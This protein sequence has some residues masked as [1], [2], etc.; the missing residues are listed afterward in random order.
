[1]TSCSAV[2]RLGAWAAIAAAL[3]AS[4]ATANADEARHTDQVGNADQVDAETE[5][6]RLLAKATQAEEQGD[7]TQAE[8]LLRESME[9]WPWSYTAFR[10]ATL[11]G[12]TGRE[13]EAI[14]LLQRIEQREFGEVEG[15]ALAEMRS[16][17]T[18]LQARLATLN[19]SW[20]SRAAVAIRLDEQLVL[21]VEDREGATLQVDPGLRRLTLEAPGA[22]AIER[23][24]QLNP[25]ATVALH[26]NFEATAPT[27]PPSEQSAS[28]RGRRLRRWLGS[29]AAVVALAVGAVLLL[30]L[31]PGN[32]EPQPILIPT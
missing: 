28:A 24:L 29:M 3:A 12:A 10:L 22:R 13:S 23:E 4:P 25:G 5:G 18:R 16:E 20:N 31:L 1:M 26:L 15:R 30:V 32:E 17:L 11:L 2:E 8:S 21:E 27:P 6:Q 14:S 7:L 19:L 9:I